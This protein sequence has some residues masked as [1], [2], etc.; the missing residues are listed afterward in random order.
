MTGNRS[1]YCGY[2][3]SSCHCP[4]V[5]ETSV[6]TLLGHTTDGVVD[7]SKHNMT[8]RYTLHVKDA[9]LTDE[10][11]YRC[12]LTVTPTVTQFDTY[13]VISG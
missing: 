7:S 11:K 9:Q 8:G 6:E 10:G 1:K 5:S 3:Q 13:L 12:M 2:L 4:Q